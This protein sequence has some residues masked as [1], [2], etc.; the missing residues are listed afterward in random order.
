MGREETPAFAAALYTEAL[1]VRTIRV[2][3]L[4]VDRSVIAGLRGVAA[5]R[6][7]G[8]LG[9]GLSAHL[10]QGAAPIIAILRGIAPAQ[11]VEVGAA[12]VAAGITIIEVPLAS[13]EP[14]FSI[15]ALQREFGDDALIAAGT[16]L[17]VAQVDAVA[18]TGAQ[19]II[20]PSLNVE[21][22]AR[23]RALGLESMPGF[24]S[25]TEAFAA[26]DAGAE[27]LKLFPASSLNR[28]HIKA[29]R[30]VL[31]TR[32]QYW[33]VGGTGVHD[34][35]VW[36]DAGARGIGVGGALYKAGDSAQ[37]V[38]VRARALIEHWRRHD[39]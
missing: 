20:S 31:P 39:P 15:A 2:E 1:A 28:S 10:S 19:L 5:R 29:I 18:D 21:V 38:S 13:P 3:A 34:L 22:I 4:E 7:R 27:H 33:A 26:T 24:L 16:V 9:M 12:L 14:L 32:T 6:F 8:M 30:E 17:S 37:V 11:A 36:L 25:T 23:T 35:S